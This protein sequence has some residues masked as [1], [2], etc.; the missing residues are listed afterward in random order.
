[1]NEDSML[2]LDT[3][4]AIRSVMSAI[5]KRNMFGEERTLFPLLSSRVFSL[6]PLPSSPSFLSYLGRQ[7]YSRFYITFHS[8]QTKSRAAATAVV[9][10]SIWMVYY[11]QTSG[12]DRSFGECYRA[13]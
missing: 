5:F 6:P 4:V 11:G 1:M 8:T 13:F 3:P 12:M 9:P 7:I 2:K 10:V